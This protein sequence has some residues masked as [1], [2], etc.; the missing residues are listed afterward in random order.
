MKKLTFG[1][2]SLHRPV[3]YGFSALWIVFLHMSV[4]IPGSPLF[5]PL[6]WLKEAG[7]AGVEIFVLLSGFGL[8]RSFRRNSDIRAFYSKRL[9]RIV[10]PTLLVTLLFSPLYD[11]SFA[12]WLGRVLFLPYWLG[13][14]TMWFASF[15]LTMY[16]IYPLIYFVQQRKPW[17]LWIFFGISVG[18]AA[19]AGWKNSG[20]WEAC[21]LGYMRI[22]AFLLGCILAPHMTDDR[23]VPRWVFPGSLAVYVVLN[24]LFRPLVTKSPIPFFV[25]CFFLAICMILALTRI[26][27]WCTNGRV[28]RFGYRF[29][30]FC[31]AYSLECYL[32]FDRI[33]HT[34]APHFTSTLAE[35]ANAALLTLAFIVPLRWLCDLTLQAF[36]R[37]AN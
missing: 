30:A 10:P 21:L 9:C 37:A 24:I 2:I 33:R 28:R 17:V 5:A 34:L 19:I 20:Y 8:Y 18:I 6:W 7:V 31:G 22:P 4:K 23:A 14:P 36:R 32:L 16:L 11:I 27:G 29:F 12:N 1:D 15:I 35:N 13:E 3:L 25:C 26:A